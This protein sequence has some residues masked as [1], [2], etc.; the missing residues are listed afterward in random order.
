MSK[1]RQLKKK[2]SML[3]LLIL[4]LVFLGFIMPVSA[5]QLGMNYYHESMMSSDNSHYIA[6][7]MEQVSADLDLILKVTPFVKLYMNPMIESNKHWVLQ[8]AEIAKQKGMHVVVVNNVDDRQLNSDNWQDY[9]TKVVQAAK[10][11]SGKADAFLVGNEISLHTTIPREELRNYIEPLINE[12]K[13]VFDKQVSYEGFWYEKDQW[14]GYREVIYFNLYEDFS[15]FNTNLEEFNNNFGSNGIIGEFGSQM[16]DSGELKDEV[17]QSN[18]INQRWDAIKKTQ[19]PVA[20]VF[21]FREP[22]PEGFGLLSPDGSFKPFL[23]QQTSNINAPLSKAK[24]S[25]MTYSVKSKPVISA[26]PTA[27]IA[28][29]A[30]EKMSINNSIKQSFANALN[31]PFNWSSTISMSLINVIIKDPTSIIAIFRTSLGNIQL[32]ITE[33]SPN[34]FEIYRQSSPTGLIFKIN[35]DSA[36]IDHVRGFN[37]F[38][39]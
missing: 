28:K 26:I 1:T 16:K 4:G 32:Q 23:A 24:L 25:T 7:T 3:K 35:L 6:R 31:F 8:I 29:P 39:R 10:E 33:K 37:N 36:Y 18:E 12:A 13:K 22:S 27:I 5:A 14:K 20:Y 11:F 2:K 38:T 21:T 17:W 30:L 19:I 15:R 9:S 34:Y